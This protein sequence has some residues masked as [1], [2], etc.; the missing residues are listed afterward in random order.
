M[1]SRRPGPARLG[2]VVGATCAGTA[3]DDAGLPLQRSP[4]ALVEAG[5]MAPVPHPGGLPDRRGRCTYHE[6]D[7][8]FWETKAAA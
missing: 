2:C 3:A 4:V 7:K 8:I 6:I 1:P 5:G